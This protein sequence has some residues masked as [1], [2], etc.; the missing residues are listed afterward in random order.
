MNRLTSKI[1]PT[2]ATVEFHP[3][4]F[5]SDSL[6]VLAEV[7]FSIVTESYKHSIRQSLS[8]LCLWVLNIVRLINLVCVI[9]ESRVSVSEQKKRISRLLH[10]LLELIHQKKSGGGG[11]GGEEE[12]EC[13]NPQPH[14]LCSPWIDSCKRH[15]FVSCTL[16]FR[17]CI[18]LTR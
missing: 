17:V 2:D 1:N 15:I 11:G 14:P 5:K 7:A 16:N 12:E 8:V 18:L 9:V 10:W 3:D 4:I 13:Y 6:K